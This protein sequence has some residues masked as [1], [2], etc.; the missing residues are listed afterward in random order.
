MKNKVQNT[1][2]VCIWF[3][4]TSILFFSY[5]NMKN[6]NDVIK[7]NEDYQWLK[8][9]E[10]SILIENMRI[11]F[12]EYKMESDITN[13]SQISENLKIEKDEREKLS[14]LYNEKSINFSWNKINNSY[15]LPKSYLYLS[16]HTCS[17]Y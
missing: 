13:A 7:I 16:C 15:N 8:N 9:Q 4:I 5:H 17:P 11:D 1:I 12:L 2:N 10:T 3:T 14:L 6:I